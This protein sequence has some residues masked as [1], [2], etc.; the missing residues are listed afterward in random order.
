MTAILMRLFWLTLPVPVGP[1]AVAFVV[2]FAAV[3]IKGWA[4]T[5]AAVGRFAAKQEI[6]ALEATI[7]AKDQI[8]DRAREIALEEAQARARARE[9]QINLMV[10]KAAADAELENVNDELAELMARPV[11]ADCR[12]GG[13]LLGR[14]RGR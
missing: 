10:A 5:R 13:D 7:K 6:A 8:A 4:E 9:A 14:L 3:S 1:L 12:V 2:L 11:A